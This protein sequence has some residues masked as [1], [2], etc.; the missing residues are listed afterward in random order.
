VTRRSRSGSDRFALPLLL[1]GLLLPAGARAQ[2]DDPPVVI[3]HANEIRRVVEGDSLTYFLAGNVRAHRGPIQMRS[4]RAAIYRQ[5]GIADFEGNVHFWDRTTEIYANRVVYEETTN[6]AHA[7]GRVQL[8]DRESG[9]QVLA[10]TIDYRRDEELAIAR[11]RPHGVI[12]P[13]DTTAEAPFDLYADEMRLK[14]DSTATEVVAVDSVLIER[15]DLTAVADSLWYDQDEGRVALRIRPKVETEGTFLTAERIDVLLTE[16]VI[17][18]LAAVEGARAI[19]KTDSIPTSVP[20]AFENVSRTSFLEGDSL[21]IAF[22]EGE[23]DWL[24]AEGKARSFNYARESPPGP[25]ETWSVNYLLGERLRLNFNGDTLDVVV[26][27]GGHRGIY[28][29]EEIRVGGPLRRESEPIPLPDL[30]AI[31]GG[32]PERGSVARRGIRSGRGNG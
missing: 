15:A 19:D 11:P 6:V 22:R 24:V 3:D 27:S 23:I 14:S 10:D 16:S 8:I 30:S 9:S 25:I 26:A 29:S 4:Q 28:R 31:A 21:Y 20:A 2:Q 5:S 1:A 7:T 13:R 32:S 18:A 12:M 17:S